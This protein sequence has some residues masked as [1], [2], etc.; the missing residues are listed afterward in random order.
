MSTS[1]SIVILASIQ[2]SAS[3]RQ[4]LIDAAKPLVTV[5]RAEEGC[6]DYEIALDVANDDRFVLAERWTSEAALGAHFQTAHFGAFVKTLIGIGAKV[7]SCIRY[8]ASG[9]KVV[10]LPPELLD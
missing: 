4:T 2:V 1:E 5:T 9:A 6:L 10:E 3:Q 8:T 7:K